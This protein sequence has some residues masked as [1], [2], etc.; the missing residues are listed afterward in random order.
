MFGRDTLLR[1]WHA[2]SLSAFVAPPTPPGNTDTTAPHNAEASGKAALYQQQVAALHGVE[3]YACLVTS[4]PVWSSSQD[5]QKISS[6]V[7][8]VDTP[9][10]TCFFQLTLC[11]DERNTLTNLTFSCGR[12]TFRGCW[13][14]V[15]K[16]ALTRFALR[17]PPLTLAQTKSTASGG[18]DLLMPGQGTIV[19]APTTNIGDSTSA[20]LPEAA[21]WDGLLAC[22]VSL[23]QW[24]SEV[25]PL[26]PLRKGD[27]E[28]MLKIACPTA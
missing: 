16:Q 14:A 28:A 6:S 15:G 13:N 7:Q 26:V 17:V 4:V 3:V 12:A 8:V 2:P 21:A 18:Q 23:E 11:D 5:G 20:S 10:T 19:R 22:H 1:Q 25:L 9:G 27:R 24:A